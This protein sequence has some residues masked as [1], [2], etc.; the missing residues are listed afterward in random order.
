M[1]TDLKTF[2]FRVGAI[3]L[4]GC[5]FAAPFAGAAEKRVAIVYS[6]TSVAKYW[7]EFGYSQLFMAMQN[8]CSMAGVPYDLLTENELTDPAKL[9]RYSVLVAPAFYYVPAAKRTQILA[10]LNTAANNGLNIITSGWF[11]ALD[12]NG[13]THGDFVQVMD[14]IIGVN[15]AATYSGV[16]IDV[17]AATTAHPAMPGYAASQVIRKYSKMWTNSFA[18]GNGADPGATT[19]LCNFKIGT[20]TDRAVIA[21]TT[22]SGRRNVHFANEQIMQDTNVMWSALQWSLYGTDPSIALRMGRQRSLFFARCD[23]DL[24]MFVDEVNAVEGKLL[25]ILT[26][27]KTKYGF[28]GA[29]YI[30]VGNNPAAGEETNW[31]V[32]G[33]LYQKYRALGN[34]IGSHSYTH[35][36]DTKL[37]TAAELEF[38]FNQSV[39]AIQANMGGTVPG[40]AVP[41]MPE[42][43]FVV[44]TVAPWLRYLSGRAAI[45]DNN[46]GYSSAF[47]RIKPGFGMGYFCLN[48]SPDFTLIGFQKKTAAQA[49]TIWKTEYANQVLNAPLPVVHWLWHDYGPVQAEAGYTK[50][51]YEAMISTA[52]A[53]SAEFVTGEDLLSRVEA[54]Q[55]AQLNVSKVDANTQTVEVTSTNAGK[56]ALALPDA[57]TVASVD[58]WYAY[59]GNKVFLPRNGGVFT[60]RT[61]TPATISRITKLPQRAELVSLW[62]NRVAMTFTVVGEGD[63]QLALNET[64]GALKVT[65][66]DLV[67]KVGST[68]TL[69]FNGNKERTVTVTPAVYKAPVA[70]AAT[71]STSKGMPVA[72]ALSATAPGNPV[73]QYT[74]TNPASGVLTGTAPNLT[75]TPNAGF[76]GTDSFTF[77]ASDGLGSSAATKVTINVANRQISVDGSLADWSGMAPAA[78]DAVDTVGTI[79][80]KNLYA[81]VDAGK[82]YLGIDNNGPVTQLNYG[83]TWYLDTDQ[84]ATSGFKAFALG[85][86]YLIE[87]VNL[88]RFTGSTQTAWSWTLVGQAT[89]AIQDKTAELAFDTAMIGGATSFDAAFYG[90]NAAFGQTTA[91]RVPQTGFIR[92]GN[93]RGGLY[94]PIAVD[95]V[96]TDWPAA[97]TA[98]LVDGNDLAGTNPLDLLQVQMTT[99]SGLFY[100]GYTNETNFPATLGWACTLYLDTDTNTNTGF[101]NGSL[102]AEFIV[103]GTTL[104][105][106]AGS[107]TDWAWTAVTSVLMAVNGPRAEMEVPLN[108]IGSPASF[109]FDV[110]ADNAAL[111]SSAGVDYI[112][113]RY[114]GNL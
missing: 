103:Q 1:K 8:Q 36:E 69:R 58:N 74:F 29:N 15:G 110:V 68:A 54:Q 12:E 65:G 57:K 39:R 31:S 35:P 70:T 97:L 61:G 73:L 109:D 55:T 21:V 59:S 26:S 22:R 86:D 9:A 75:Y 78:T 77:Q 62:G 43:M 87:G 79:D 53:G 90:N 28:V 49:T 3:V 88:Y 48:T 100:V 80:I 108:S 113:G 37:L 11:M 94:T 101:R 13:A 32:S 51:M 20:K 47:G 2:L 107:G 18:P 16:A 105:K 112:R 63:V 10:T 56:F 104:Y 72:F 40:A 81:W 102:G 76:Y 84:N 33:P 106:Y 41:G 67:V 23:M 4:L 93:G 99:Q 114:L 14:S 111:G 44:N 96:L 50:A 30:N 98:V 5:C 95:G 64:G 25:P 89:G 66:A 52:F 38:E 82:I 42:N 34:E 24:S 92:F 7:D 19:T 60:V 91:D 71:V 17:I 46:L 6:E 83:Y 45:A 85:A 27:W